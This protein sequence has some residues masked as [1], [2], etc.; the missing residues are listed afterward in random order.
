[1]RKQER[2]W[3]ERMRSR[4][5][6]QDESR[7]NVWLFEWTRAE[8]PT[9][10]AKAH[11]LSNNHNAGNGLVMPF[12]LIAFVARSLASGIHGIHWHPLASIKCFHELA[13]YIE[14]EPPQ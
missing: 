2:G 13:S 14:L 8:R 9:H 11:A 5:R 3:E 4:T 10:S 1:M 6:R 7:N 12:Q